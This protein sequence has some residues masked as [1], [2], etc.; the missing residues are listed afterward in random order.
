MNTKQMTTPIAKRTQRKGTKPGSASKTPL[1]HQTAAALGQPTRQEHA[2]T[3]STR[4]QSS[5]PAEQVTVVEAKIDIGFGNRLFIRGQGA[6]LSWLNGVPLDCIDADTWV[7]SCTQAKNKVV[8]KLLLNDEIWA[9][10]ED[11]V[12]EAGRKIETIPCFQPRS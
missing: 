1:P 7:W 4:T 5:S 12:A 2:P 10:G 11:V 6:G 9:Q 8:F 3:E